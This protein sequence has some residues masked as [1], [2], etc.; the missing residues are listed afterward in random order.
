MSLDDYARQSAYSDPRAYTQLFDKLP[1]DPGELSAVVRNVIVHYRENPSPLRMAEIDNRWID[2]SLESDQSRTG[3]P[4]DQPRPTAERVV[5]CCRDFSLLTVA[6]L[7]H[8]GVP[9]R[10]RIGF[11]NYFA[12]DWHHDHVVVD[13]WDGGRW[14]FL[15]PE[16][17]P[18]GS[19][20][21]DPMDMPRLAGGDAL[22]E[23]F[24][25]AA[26][27]WSSFRRGE[28]DG[29]NYG[30]DRGH[31]VHGGWFIRNYVIGEL[32]HRQRDEL[33]LWDLW[34][35][36]SVSLEGDLGLI[37]DIAALLLAGDAGDGPAERALAERYRADP[38]LRPGEEVT[39]MSP[40]ERQ[41]Q[42]DLRARAEV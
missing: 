17:D 16:L 22:T 4:L 29:E 14:V 32:A 40:T 23:P 12:D 41:F 25:T 10:T 8:Q 19:W 11:A 30:V 5:G 26:Q 7:R 42:V 27:V 28:I 34:G 1:T 20:T 33:L 24:V 39:C 15:D 37:D 3:A 13:H 9:A 18:A 2:R 36:M 35:D 21:F 6:A 38:R 31:P